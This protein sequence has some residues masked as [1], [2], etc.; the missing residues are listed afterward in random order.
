VLLR[1]NILHFNSQFFGHEAKDRED[2][3]SSNKGCHAVPDTDDGGVPEDVVVEPVVA[4][5]GDQTTSHG[6][7]EEDLH[8]CCL[9]HPEENIASEITD[10]FLLLDISKSGPLRNQVESNSQG[11]SIQRDG[12]DEENDQ[13]QVREGGCHVDHLATRL[14]SLII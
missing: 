6:Q 14:D 9:P 3:K 5:Q 11:C 1:C 2:G 8:S 12:P 13:Q 10:I 4:G 7:G